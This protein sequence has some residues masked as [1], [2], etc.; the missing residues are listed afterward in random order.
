[1][2]KASRARLHRR[3]LSIDENRHC[4]TASTL[5]PKQDVSRE[6]HPGNVLAFHFAV[7]ATNASHVVAVLGHI[8]RRRMPPPPAARHCCRRRCRC[9]KGQGAR[10]QGQAGPCLV[11]GAR[12]P[13][14]ILLYCLLYC[15]LDC[16][17]YWLL[18]CLLY[19]LLHCLW[20][21]TQK[22]T[23]QGPGPAQRLF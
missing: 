8:I 12:V 5:Y 10:G 19:C 7:C 2:L 14:P 11:T 18:Y 1:M 17:L 16:L 15:L 13:W 22:T 3:K 23:V 9:R 20:P 6:V 4:L 21:G